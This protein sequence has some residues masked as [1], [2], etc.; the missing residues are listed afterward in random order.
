MLHK[1]RNH[2]FFALIIVLI[3]CIGI[4]LSFLY[5]L[6]SCV[7][8]G[9]I[10][11]V[12]FIRWLYRI[13]KQPVRKVAFLLDAIDN[14]DAAIHFYE[15]TAQDDISQVNGMLNK[16]ARILYNTKQD[17][18]QREKY[19]ELIL[20][21]VDT[22]IVVLNS[23][24]AVYQ[25]NN[26]AMQ[27]LG[28]TVFTHLRQLEKNSTPLM[29]LLEQVRPGYKGQI[30]LD[31]EHE[32]L[33]LAIRVSGIK[34][35]DEELRIVALSNINRELDEKEMDAWIQLIRVLTH[36]I[37]NSLTPVTSISE[38][39]L[40]LP[41]A[42]SREM[43]QGLETIHT[44]GKG[45]I[46]FVGSFRQLT[47]MPHPEPALFDVLPFLE[48]MIN[49]ALHQSIKEHITINLI[50]VNSELMLYADEQ[51]LGQVVINI[52]NNAVQAIEKQK[53]GIINIRAYCDE[54]ESVIIEI[55]NNGPRI[56]SE[57]ANQIF[58]P[59]FTTKENG[60]GIG[61]SISKQIMRLIGGTLTLL[62]YKN[63][64][65]LTTFVL[66]IA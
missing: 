62:P 66:K 46:G 56:T 2:F 36:E 26:A 50:D 33:Q 25:K 49:L 8:I 16:I 10:A 65:Q 28:M 12:F 13:C 39:L 5:G 61:L 22:G 59:F 24:G 45:L 23:A 15:H 54:Y 14:D 51:L 19:Y 21:F 27:L 44:T 7:I 55:A 20:D 11:E 1:L 64:T 38:T 58:I 32:S 52:L 17:V 42:K 37:M 53:E 3:F 4:T 43:K 18:V 63:E 47:R 29:H 41:D 40:N 48:R 35:K 57:T 9:L 60:S 31:N 30:P 34:I 6:W